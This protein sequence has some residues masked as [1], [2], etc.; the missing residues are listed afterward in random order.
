MCGGCTYAWVEGQTPHLD[1]VEGLPFGIWQSRFSIN[2]I[3]PELAGPAKRPAP[4]APVR[5][6]EH[7]RS[8]TPFRKR[9]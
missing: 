1:F 4:L 7:I 3:L 6:G 5:S 9:V 2:R 8:K